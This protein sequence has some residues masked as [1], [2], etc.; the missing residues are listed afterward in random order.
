VKEDFFHDQSSGIVMLGGKTTSLKDFIGKQINKDMLLV[1]ISSMSDGLLMM[2]G[3]T[4]S[5]SE[6]EIF[7]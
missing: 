6:K 4:G 2:A 7:Q 1:T 5:C 3:M